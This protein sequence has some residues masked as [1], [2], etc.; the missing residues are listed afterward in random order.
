LPDDVFVAAL[1]VPP[2]SAKVAIV[3]R[4]AFGI[5]CNVPA[6][7]IYADD[8]MELLTSMMLTGWDRVDFFLALESQLEWKIDW[9]MPLPRISH[10]SIFG[11]RITGA[12]PFGKWVASAIPS[13]VPK[14]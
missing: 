12:E 10:E 7:S 4:R 1:R 6:T 2:S 8:K 13:I 14:V 11:E 3:V 5:C 9:R